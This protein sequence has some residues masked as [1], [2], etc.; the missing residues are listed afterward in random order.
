MKFL[1]RIAIA[2]ALWGQPALAQQ[3]PYVHGGTLGTSQSQVLGNDPQRHKILL[4]NPNA[5]GSIAFCPVGPNRDTGA[6]ITCTVNGPGSITLQ[7]YQAIV[8]DSNNGSGPMLY[9]PSA[10]Y[11]V[12]ASP[13]LN[14][15]IL[16]FE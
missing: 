3:P 11:G 15:T 10:W 5:S 14:Y 7:P 12:S 8:F 6:A 9:L 13:G 16:E 4:F 1:R 2:L